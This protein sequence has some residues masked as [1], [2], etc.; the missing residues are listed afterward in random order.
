M[1][2]V[3]YKNIGNQPC[4]QTIKLFIVNYSLLIIHC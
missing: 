4:I 2:N 1:N 3:E